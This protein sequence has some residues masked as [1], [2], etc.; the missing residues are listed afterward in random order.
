MKEKR[1]QEKIKMLRVVNNQDVPV[2]KFADDV[3]RSRVQHIGLCLEN[4]LQ[5]GTIPVTYEDLLHHS[6]I[7]QGYLSAAT[8]VQGK[9]EK[10]FDK[11]NEQLKEYDIFGSHILLYL[12]LS[13]N[14]ADHTQWKTELNRFL[15]N[16]YEANKYNSIK[17]LIKWGMTRTDK[18][19]DGMAKLMI[20]SSGY[21][22]VNEN[23]Q[24]IDLDLHHQY[25][26]GIISNAHKC[27]FDVFLPSIVLGIGD[28]Y[29]YYNYACKDIII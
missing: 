11:A 22:K 9:A 24:E 29:T 21:T 3:P 25:D 4:I 17:P 23:G 5:G 15:V 28:H 12:W 2:F 13:H 8:L 20:I 10:L 27:Q 1:K 26:A 7:I 19:E 18:I 16:F 6:Q 14:D